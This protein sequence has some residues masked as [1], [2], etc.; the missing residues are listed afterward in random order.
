MPLI[1]KLVN[2]IS[3]II[4]ETVDDSMKELNTIAIETF[5]PKKP[6]DDLRIMK[7]LYVS[8]SNSTFLKTS[9]V[10][11]SDL[12]DDEKFY[13]H[14]GYE[15][16]ILDYSYDEKTD[17]I[18]IELLTPLA[19]SKIK[20]RFYYIYRHHVAFVGINLNVDQPILSTA[21]LVA[22]NA[23]YVKKFADDADTL[24]DSQKHLIAEGTKL[25]ISKYE[26]VNPTNIRINL[27]DP[28]KFNDQ[29]E[30]ELKI[31][32][33][34]LNDIEHIPFQV[35]AVADT[36]IKIKPLQVAEL[37]V[38]ETI[39]LKQG[40]IFFI[41]DYDEIITDNSYIKV[42][43]N[44][45]VRINKDDSSD[46]WDE[47]YIYKPHVELLSFDS[48]NK[49]KDGIT[50]EP[51]QLATPVDRGFEISLPGIGSIFTDEP[52]IGNGNFY[53]REALHFNKKTQAYRRPENERVVKNIIKIANTMEEVRNYMGDRPIR[54][55]SWYRDPITNSRVGGASKSRH[56]SG[57]AVD[58]VVK[59]I[60]PHR[61]YSELNPWYKSRGG[62]ASSTVFTH[63]DGRGYKARWSYGY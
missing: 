37:G 58:F 34:D 1:R 48:K 20:N 31:L 29:D 26:T 62:L 32:Y 47:F 16:P 63:I 17:H 3:S 11:S 33:I 24:G 18:F 57:D 15:F 52:I 2:F 42:V 54:V 39:L 35:N 5:V 4:N 44:F 7:Q 41:N 28:I 50:D 30:S 19:Q 22:K 38:N 46:V 45:P 23:T 27:V 10:Q 59:G 9:P 6:E 12:N 8:L 14:L 61:V 49:P 36:W 51:V 25:L 60:H 40:S 56:L 55:N 43:P 53:W 21:T 13:F